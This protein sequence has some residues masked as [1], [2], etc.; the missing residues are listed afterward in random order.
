MLAYAD[1][2]AQVLVR[3]RRLAAAKAIATWHHVT[4][5]RGRLRILSRRLLL[6]LAHS[7]LSSAFQAWTLK[8]P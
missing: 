2:Y 4:C 7:E 3:W 8:T 1:A 6:H 5:E